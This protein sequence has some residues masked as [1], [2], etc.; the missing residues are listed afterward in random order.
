MV[1]VIVLNWNG[2]EDTIACAE[3]VLSLTGESFRL[4]VCDNA[5]ADDSI[6]RLRAWANSRSLREQSGAKGAAGANLSRPFLELRNDSDCWKHPPLAH[7]EMV[8][9]QTGA[10]LG[11]AGGNN[12]GI[13]YALS[14]GDAEF[15]WILNNDTVVTPSAL[16]ALLAKA[17]S[18]SRYGIVGSTLLYHSRPDH[19]QVLGGCSFSAWTTSVKPLGWGKT[20]TQAANVSETA[21]EAQLDYVAGA[22]MLVSRAFIA[23]VGLMQEDYFLY[24]EEIDWAERGRRSEKQLWKLG[25]ARDSVVLHKVGASAGTGTTE[26][27]TRRIYTSKLRFM[28]RFYPARNIVTAMMILLQAA[29]SVFTAGFGHARVILAV[30]LTWRSISVSSKVSLSH[31]DDQVR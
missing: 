8:L 11:F 21:I 13:R 3:S 7:G 23:D 26:S 1:Y 2:A 16:S 22:S 28:K 27:S 18:D 25:F 4:V 5:S 15:F 19:V 6:T 30:L 31:A 29:K 20:A 24:Y 12:V 14:R 9:I 17:A 10:N